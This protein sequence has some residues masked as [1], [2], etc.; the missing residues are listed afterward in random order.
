[1]P[2]PALNPEH[3][4]KALESAGKALTAAIEASGSGLHRQATIYDGSKENEV[5][6]ALK[7]GREEAMNAIYGKDA[8]GGRVAAIRSA[9]SYEDIYR[10]LAEHDAFASHQ[11][12]HIT[13]HLLAEHSKAFLRAI[14]EL[15][16]E[17]AAMRQRS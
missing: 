11:A 15:E 6:D 13:Q 7:R 14:A 10:Q 4:E 1:M 9:G 2:C 8:S 12:P 16:P 3:I 17:A 5:D